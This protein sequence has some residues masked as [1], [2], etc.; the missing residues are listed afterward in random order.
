MFPQSQLNPPELCEHTSYCNVPEFGKTESLS[1]SISPCSALA[2]STQ[3]LWF[4]Q[5]H[6]FCG[7][8]CIVQRPQGVLTLTSN[9]F[10]S[11]WLPVNWLQDRPLAGGMG[12]FASHVVDIVS[13]CHRFSFPSYSTPSLCHLFLPGHKR[14]CS[15]LLHSCATQGK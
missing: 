11:K 12:S 14:P 1:L 4:D 9:C 5:L 10:L 7:P 8:L 2:E 3:L 15:S 6:D 13:V